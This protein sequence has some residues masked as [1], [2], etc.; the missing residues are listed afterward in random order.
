[1]TTHRVPTIYV[2]VI[3][4][5][6]ENLRTV[7]SLFRGVPSLVFEL[8]A[9]DLLDHHQ[10]RLLRSYSGMG[11]DRVANIAAARLLYPHAAAHLVIDGGTAL[12]YTTV[13]RMALMSSSSSGTASPTSTRNS[14]T[15]QPLT[16]VATTT[17]NHNNCTGSSISCARL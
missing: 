4:T 16:S 12:T 17:T 13:M 10:L 1:M 3:S 9:D 8:T 2:Y 5:S 6:P 7:A 15:L 11:V 14:S